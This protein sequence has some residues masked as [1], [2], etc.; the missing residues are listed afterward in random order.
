MTSSPVCQAYAVQT[1][2]IRTSEVS[3]MPTGLDKILSNEEIDAL[4]TLIR[5]LN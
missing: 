4:V 2:C 1:R 3:L 5:Q